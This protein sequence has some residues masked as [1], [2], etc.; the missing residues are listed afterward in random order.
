MLKLE[1]EV[2]VH[3]SVQYGSILMLLEDSTDSAWICLGKAKLTGEIEDMSEKEVK[4]KQINA[5][6]K[7]MLDIRVEADVK[8]ERVEEEIQSLMALEVSDE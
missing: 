6:R 3:K 2:Y 4:L 5:L 1:Q 7:R 8:I